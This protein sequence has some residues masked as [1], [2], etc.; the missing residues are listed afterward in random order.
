VEDLGGGGFKLVGADGSNP[1]TSRAQ[2]VVYG[3]N[4]PLNTTSYVATALSDETLTYDFEFL[5]FDFFGTPFDPAGEL[6][7]GV[8]TQLSISL[9]EQIGGNNA[10]QFGT[11][12]FDLHAGDTYGFYVHTDSVEGPG[13]ITLTPQLAS[14]PEPSTWAMLLTGFL[15]L[16][17]VLRRR[18]ALAW[19][20]ISRPTWR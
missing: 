7:N 9:P 6:V 5:T 19:G 8:Q 14:V 16:G 12:T 11:V 4:Q 20:A 13:T 10:P 18:R 2:Q 3:E 17:A 1:G 15:G